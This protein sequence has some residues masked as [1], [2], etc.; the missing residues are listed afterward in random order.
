[1]RRI[2]YASVCAVLL[3]APVKI[4]AQTDT[5]RELSPAV[6]EAVDRLYPGFMEVLESGDTFHLKRLSDALSVSQMPEAFP[7][8]A[9][10]LEH[11]PESDP[12]TIS[13]ALIKL[14][15]SMTTIPATPLLRALHNGNA[16]QRRAAAFVLL[17]S[18]SLIPEA[19]RSSVE[20][21]LIGA[22]SD[23]SIDVRTWAAM[24]LRESGTPAAA[25]ALAAAVKDR[26]VTSRLYSIATGTRRFSPSHARPA[27]P[28]ELTTRIDAVSRGF[29]DVLQSGDEQG[30]RRL[31]DAIARLRTADAA[32]VLGWIL[33]N[34]D[35]AA[36]GDWVAGLLADNQQSSGAVAIADIAA[37]L[38]KPDPD[39]RFAAATF[40]ERLFSQRVPK[41]SD[42]E[43]AQAIDA[44]ITA[45]ADAS[46]DVARM[47]ADALGRARAREAVDA[48][49]RSLDRQ[50]ASRI[51][52]RRVFNALGSIG[53]PAAVPIFETWTR[54]PR[55]FKLR[56]AA[57][58][59][60]VGLGRPSDRGA[61]ARA[62]LWEQLDTKLERDVLAGGKD[63]LPAVWQALSGTAGPEKHAALALVAWVRD[64]RSVPYVVQALE[65]THG[66]L[67]REQL[68]FDLNVILL[69]E[70][71]QLT[72]PPDISAIA[73]QHI[74]QVID[75]IA[76][77]PQNSS[78]RPCS[79]GFVV[80][81][82]GFSASFEP[83]AARAPVSIASSP[84]AFDDWLKKAPNG[85]G[86]A[87]HPVHA[88]DGVA[89]VASTLYSPHGGGTS[90]ITLHRKTASGWTAIPMPPLEQR[91]V[92]STTLNF[93]PTIERD[94]G[95]QDPLK[96]VRLDAL[97]QRIDRHYSERGLLAIEN[98]DV[99]DELTEVD[100][101][102]VPLLQHYRTST[103]ANIRYAAEF[104][105]AR[106]T[107]AP[108]VQTMILAI[109][110]QPDG[111]LRRDAT[112]ILSS[113]MQRQF[114][115]HGTFAAA[116]ER[117]DVVSALLASK[118]RDV[119]ANLPRANQVM[120]VR[121][122][123]RFAIADVRLGSSGYSALFERRGDQ[124]VFVM[125]VSSW[126]E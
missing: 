86:I 23:S 120:A 8:L 125:V 21:A 40:F 121:R 114:K 116:A 83:D 57:A 55:D 48:L 108:D 39:R 90:W 77:V 50:D 6:V 22:L 45:L 126:I 31:I 16:D 99:P 65:Y 113:Y 105:L 35:A 1:M 80:D 111:P 19:E 69:T 5:A 84:A 94:Y 3:C 56:A 81:L 73:A 15:S 14:K 119:P 53:D 26:D 91:L 124:W 100:A 41:I 88:A 37:L 122:W 87:F 62:L 71:P 17:D 38:R 75:T 93:Y 78:S 11:R 96:I 52:L 59:A 110:E 60:A 30:I 63:A 33:E 107:G 112:Q 4:A 25:S 29:V 43:R 79:D 82:R 85:C 10:M 7:V 54:A 27:F 76:A 61:A 68:L 36:Y 66:A 18:R 2:L 44:L 109:D 64:A 13:V 72:S 106:L 12:E 117:A 115:T 32:A 95:G 118:G 46:L 98:V 34:G 42:P 123:D 28:M 92:S 101:S 89:R 102:Y 58:Q 47:A 49:V 24:S 103:S 67:S 51:Y 97:M 104:E 74:A 9:W 20:R 70:A